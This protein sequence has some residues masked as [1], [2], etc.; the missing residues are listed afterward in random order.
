MNIPYQRERGGC[1]FFFPNK[2]QLQDY[3]KA[4]ESS[5]TSVPGDNVSAK[6]CNRINDHYDMGELYMKFIKDTFEIKKEQGCAL[7]T[8][9]WQ[10]EVKLNSQRKLVIQ[11]R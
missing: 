5:K 2:T 4:S 3:M 7:C 6:I 8:N 11:E 10:G 1:P 9:G